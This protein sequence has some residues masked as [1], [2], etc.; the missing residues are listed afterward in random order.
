MVAYFE[1]IDKALGYYNSYNR[2]ALIG[3]FNS[4]DH[5]NCMETF[6][7]Q[8]NLENIV[9]E[10][11]RFKNSSKPSNIDLFFTN[12]SSYFKNAKKFLMGLSDFHKLV[13]AMPKISFP[14]TKPLE[15]NYRN[16]K[17]LN[18]YRI[19]KARKLDFNDSDIQ[20]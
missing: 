9:K 12:N 20:T 13:T 11:T 10:R 5:K 14:K 8:H 6:L 3:D 1:A 16:Y 4:E 15:I 18:E 2:I 7:Y 17:H 19:N